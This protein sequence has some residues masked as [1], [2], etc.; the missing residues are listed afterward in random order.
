MKYN[1]K[2]NTAIFLSSQA[3]SILGSSL[4]QFAITSYIT[5]QTKSGVYATVAILCA[6][7]PMFLVSPF[8][9]VWADRYNRK[10]LIVLADGGIA[11][12][13]LVVAV[14]FLTGHGSIGLLFAALVIRG[15][16]SAIQSPCV[17]ALLPDIVPE[18]HLTRVN[19][20]NGSMQSLFSLAS[21]VL[22]ALLLSMVPLGMIFFVDIITAVIAITIMLTAFKLPEKIKEKAGQTVSYFTEMKQGIQYIKRNRFLVEFF[23]FCMVY[24]IMM[25]PAA[26]LTQVQV[27]R[28]YGD[29]YWYLSAIEVAFS[30]G[31]LI[32]GIFITVWGGLK[33]KVHTMMVSVVIMAACAFALGIRMPFA[34]YV[35]FMGLFGAAMPLLNTAAVTLLQEKVDSQYMGRVFGIMTM[36]NTSMMPLGMVIFGPVAD[37]ISIE[38][39]LLGTGVVTFIAA[40]CMSRAKA[41]LKAGR[42]AAPALD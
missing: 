8:A 10:L 13:T 25:A 20:I 6:I 27:V 39:L 38:T 4:V 24:F 15:L 33:N 19:G 26:F 31:M 9:G 14:L 12:C 41:L 37:Y 3:I 21:P 5:V 11:L 40:L 2:K 30:A 22:G 23:G 7:L 36:I 34:P 35:L 1:W 29:D 18:E 42:G 28:N 16:G 32:G 17:G